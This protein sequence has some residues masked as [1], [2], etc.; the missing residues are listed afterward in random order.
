MKTKRTIYL[1]KIIKLI[2]KNDLIA[3]NKSKNWII[4]AIVLFLTI[5]FVYSKT[6]SLIM[7]PTEHS[8]ERIIGC[9][10]QVDHF[11]T[12]EEN[13]YDYCGMLMEFLQDT[14]HAWTSRQVYDLKNCM[15]GLYGK[16]VSIFDH[17]FEVG[18][19]SFG[20]EKSDVFISFFYILDGDHNTQNQTLL[21]RSFYDAGSKNTTIHEEV[22]LKF[23][24]I[25]D[26]DLSIVAIVEGETVV[27][28]DNTYSFNCNV[29]SPRN[30][31]FFFHA[32]HEDS[33]TYTSISSTSSLG[34]RIKRNPDN[35]NYTYQVPDETW[36]FTGAPFDPSQ[37]I[38]CDLAQEGI[39]DVTAASADVHI[40][41]ANEDKKL[42]R[43]LIFT[44]G[45]DLGNEVIYD[46][47]YDYKVIRRGALGWDTFV[48]GI[49]ENEFNQDPLT[50]SP[51][52]I[53][54]LLSSGY[55]VLFVDFHH[56]S[57]WIQANGECLISILERVNEEKTGDDM[58]IVI[59]PSMG[60]QIARWALATMES[61]D[62]NHC[63]STY[64]SFDSPQKGANIPLSLQALAY[65]F[66]L[67]DPENGADLW[68]GLNNP[69]PKQLLVT[70]LD[71]MNG[72]ATECIRESYVAEMEA[73][74][75]PQKTSNVGIA[76][77]SGV[78]TPVAGS[79]PSNLNLKLF[80]AFVKDAGCVYFQ[81]ILSAD[82]GS[83]SNYFIN[84]HCYNPSRYETIYFGK[85]PYK[86]LSLI[87]IPKKYS[88]LEITRKG[89]EYEVLHRFKTKGVNGWLWENELKSF[90][91]KEN[92]DGWDTAPGCFRTD[93]NGSVSRV[94]ENSDPRVKINGIP[95]NITFMPIISLLDIN[96]EDLY[97][98][99]ST[100]LNVGVNNNKAIT[101]FDLVYFTT[102][103]NREHV[104]IT[105]DIINFV[106]NN[107]LQSST[108]P[109]VL[110]SRYNYAHPSQTHIPSTTIESGGEL[111]VNGDG[112]GGF[113]DISLEASAGRL[114]LFKVLTGSCNRGII[115][116]KRGGVIRLAELDNFKAQLTIGKDDKLFIRNGG[117]LEVNHGSSLI[118]DEDAEL[119]LEEGAMVALNHGSR[120]E[121]K[122]K[123]T[124]RD[125]VRIH[126]QGPIVIH[127]SAEIVGK[128][129][130]D[131]RGQ[132]GSVPSFH[133]RIL[134]LSE[135]KSLEIDQIQ[136][137]LTNGAIGLN[138]GASI[139][140]KESGNLSLK[141]VRVHPIASSN[142][143]VADYTDERSAIA[144]VDGGQINLEN[145]LIENFYQGLYL[146]G[147]NL[148]EDLT[149][150][151]LQMINCLKGI[152]A[153]DLRDLK[154]KDVQIDKGS[155]IQIGQPANP[156]W[157]F[158]AYGIYL[159][160]T[161]LIGENLRVMNFHNSTGIYAPATS[162]SSGS[163]IWLSKCSTIKSNKV[164]I[165]L[166]G[167][168]SDDGIYP[169]WGLLH[170]SGVSIK[171]NMEAGVQGNDILLHID[172]VNNPGHRSN[173][174]LPCLTG[175]G[176]APDPTGCFMF[177]ICY[178]ARDVAYI[179]MRGNYWGTASALGSS[180]PVGI[181][182]NRITRTRMGL[183]CSYP[184]IQIYE[185][186]IRD[187]RLIEFCDN[188]DEEEPIYYLLPNN[189][190]GGD[191]K[192]D[193][194]EPHFCDSGDS[195]VSRR[196]QFYESFELWNIGL[197]ESAMS[198]W[199]SLAFRSEINE[200]CRYY[201]DYAL[202]MSP[203][204]QPEHFQPL[205]KA[206]LDNAYQNTTSTNIYP[207]P[208]NDWLH[209][210]GIGLAG[211]QYQI[212]D[213]N[214]RVQLGGMVQEEQ[215][216]IDLS[217]LHTGLYFILITD[218]SDG[219][220]VKEIF[221]LIKL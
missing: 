113:G 138:R 87:P 131:V 129:H 161:N 25:S 152:Y 32:N 50:L 135:T 218:V 85:I 70:H 98:P 190:E 56:G 160:G 106:T 173:V 9:Q 55:D 180:A 77:A 69:A 42:R 201:T 221:K 146:S 130:L 112:D 3:K 93:L 47:D 121:I 53:G 155:G 40:L 43:P 169:D 103:A 205:T 24:A 101:P 97:Y 94:I 149:I 144:V 164:G 8:D 215:S 66:S 89:N 165:Y 68:A 104:E 116:V 72:G 6:D 151:K 191:G 110:T 5:G 132:F 186:Y 71:Y 166:E 216:S 211:K 185:P 54:E 134:E 65:H 83:N 203:Y 90:T 202:V 115:D 145:A 76:C 140:V 214:G 22:V 181:A 158:Q 167:G 46:K 14:T 17:S 208:A 188:P 182:R 13:E 82:G 64:V 137:S 143:N 100:N 196:D 142:L 81:S 86:N 27:I 207:N 171:E 26:P 148:K 127:P 118:I 48:T 147:T 128:G 124:V 102:G 60:G 220:L 170:L 177:D 193:Y 105:N 168:I 34:F 12:E 183:K 153:E 122:G 120:I 45:L 73:L 18:S 156:N 61:R 206:E 4:V 78:G 139:R 44:D 219:N 92:L 157:S 99:V 51:R 114:L 75:Y 195:D 119:I 91:S 31:N 154:L 62:I 21:F 187:S 163:N 84:R 108:A 209:L 111:V 141:G 212:L 52:M 117:S 175:E 29:V 63:T 174:F 172:A 15:E 67:F 204:R 213:I 123:L 198:G 38:D 133:D 150:N 11:F 95:T 36:I 1:S 2:E 16:E 10:D 96:T 37:G 23:P 179:Y 107:I 57:T 49:F 41:Y 20:R 59:G 197:K 210:S 88:F 176:F 178:E 79:H 162:P 199:E 189:N 33:N 58:N 159:T 200:E 7:T 80:D 109:N 192:I 35:I 19:R 184:V 74:G 136:L 126:S 125:H 194:I 39:G 217:T 28:N 30:I